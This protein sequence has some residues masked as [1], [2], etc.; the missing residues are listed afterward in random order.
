MTPTVWETE[1]GGAA[2]AFRFKGAR[3]MFWGVSGPDAGQLEISVDGRTPA[4]KVNLCNREYPFLYI[5]ALADGLDPAAIH[6][7]SVTVL[8]EPDRTLL[9]GYLRKPVAELLAQTRFRGNWVRLSHI[10]VLGEVIE[11]AEPAH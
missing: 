10:M 1:Q 2:L 7:V 3:A 6:S 9:A 4:Q 5:V 8:P 11:A